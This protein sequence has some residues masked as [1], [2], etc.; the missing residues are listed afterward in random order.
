MGAHRAGAMAPAPSRV[1]AA[2]PAPRR[3]TRSALPAAACGHRVLTPIGVLISLKPG[4]IALLRAR[5][6]PA[7]GRTGAFLIVLRKVPTT[8]ARFSST[9]SCRR[10]GASG[11][12]FSYLLAVSLR[13]Q[14]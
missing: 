2:C 13:L 1:P 12:F 14:T 8:R 7:G 11:Q 5:A 3:R 9:V 10:Y 4:Q 6:P